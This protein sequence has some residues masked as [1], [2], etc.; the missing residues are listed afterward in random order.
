MTSYNIKELIAIKQRADVLEEGQIKWL[1]KE[2]VGKNIHDAQIGALL[3]A[4]YLQGKLTE[5]ATEDVL[6]NKFACNF[7]EKEFRHRCFT[8]N[9]EKFLRTP[10]LQNTSVP[11]LLN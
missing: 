6:L 4:I 8:V 3:M 5:V 11:L 9:F 2:I 10:F 1:V 7:I